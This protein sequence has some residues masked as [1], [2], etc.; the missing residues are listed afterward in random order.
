M[1]KYVIRL[2]DA[3]PY[4]D[5]EKWDRIE[6]LLDRYSIKPIVGIIPDC[7]DEEFRKYNIINNFWENYAVKW[8]NKKWI[9]AQHGLNHN[10]SIKIR[11]EY[12]GK[13]YKNQKNNLEKGNNILKNKNIKPICFF[14]PAHTF[15]DNTIR[16]CKDLGCFQFISD[17]VALYPYKQNGMIFLPNIF[18]TPHKILP[19]GIY[20]F[21]YHPNNMKKEDYDYLEDFIIKNREKFDVNIDTLLSEYTN[22]KRNILDKIISILIKLLRKIKGTK[23]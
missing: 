5:K 13:S 2:D 9:I 23:R 21:V 7:Q 20:T 8:Q 14:A 11:T 10:L 12:A 4:M 3:C 22:R 19:F 18:D 1:L 17:G 6:K 15:D 16:A